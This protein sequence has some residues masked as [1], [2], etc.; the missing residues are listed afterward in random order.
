V[1]RSRFRPARRLPLLIAATL[2]SCAGPASP[3]LEVAGVEFTE[4]QVAGLPAPQIAVLEDLAAVGRLVADGQVEVLVR[5]LVE[6]DRE[7]SRLETLP[8]HLGALRMGL[9]GAALREAYNA[10]PEWELTVRHLVRLAPATASPTERRD[11][12]RI[13]EEAAERAAAGEDLGTL[14]TGLSEEPG[15]RETGGLL[16]PGREGS[17]VA[18][19]WEAARRLEPG[20][21]SGVV[22]S[23][24]GYHVLRLEARRPVPF[25]SVSRAPLLRRLVPRATA[26]AAMEEWAATRPP[27]ET[28]D[29]GILRARERLLEGVRLEDA[30][31]LAA[32]GAH[33]YSSDDLALA[34]VQEAADAREALVTGAPEAFVDWVREDARETIWAR[35]AA[36]EGADPGGG[37]TTD[38]AGRVQRGAAALGFRPDQ[39]GTRI[40]DLA[41]AALASRGQEERIARAEIAAFRPLLRARYRAAGMASAPSA[42]SSS[43]SEMR[44]SEN[45]R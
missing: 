30:P 7:R 45:T 12:R 37:S 8:Y 19:F 18:P 20:E 27:I 13:A 39:E 25:D 22:E 31:R 42:S 32:S 17:W 5:P 26:V 36:A 6:R 10:D 21:V 41:L 35:A 23:E 34:W 40:A 1:S 4:D 14:A 43:S 29:A 38:W 9:S 24:Y 11:A 3:A 28:D 16:R 2:L 33:A 44:N 15:A